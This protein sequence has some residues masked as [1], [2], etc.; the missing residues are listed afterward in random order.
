M[1][2]DKIADGKDQLIA[3]EEENDSMQNDDENEGS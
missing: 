1:H 3:D 2:L